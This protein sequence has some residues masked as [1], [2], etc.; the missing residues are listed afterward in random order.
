M[1]I[2]A[3]QY[4]EARRYVSPFRHTLVGEV[5]GIS[6]SRARPIKTLKVA[7]DTVRTEGEQRSTGVEFHEELPR[8][9]KFSDPLVSI[10]PPTFHKLIIVQRGQR[11]M[12]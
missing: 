6:Q 4:V 10:I 3:V 11:Q 7:D 9:P 12:K 8:F 5:Q 1:I 2:H